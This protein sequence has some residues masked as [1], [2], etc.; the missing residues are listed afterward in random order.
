MSLIIQLGTELYSASCFRQCCKRLLSWST[1]IAHPKDSGRKPPDDTRNDTKERK[2]GVDTLGYANTLGCAV[3]KT[4]TRKAPQRARRLLLN[5]VPI[6]RAHP[7]HVHAHLHAREEERG[8]AA[9]TTPPINAAVEVTTRAA[10]F[11]GRPRSRRKWAAIF[12]FFSAVN[13]RRTQQEMHQHAQRDEV[14]M[15]IDNTDT[16]ELYTCIQLAKETTGRNGT[17]V[18]GKHRAYF[19][20][21]Q[22]KKRGPRAAAVSVVV[23]ASTSGAL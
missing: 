2:R 7:F 4:R 9:R 22:K 11:E 10:L 21:L 6:L 8:A 5:G 1:G 19:S 18:T 3:S 13:V 23:S 20:S 15:H 17:Y 16:F 12:F 14:A